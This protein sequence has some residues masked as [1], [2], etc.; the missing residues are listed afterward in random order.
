MK[1]LDKWAERIYAETDVGRSIATSVA[2]VMGLSVY[3]LSSDW[4]IALFSAVIAFP[5]VRLVATGFHARAVRRAQVQME[6][7]EADRKRPVN[8]S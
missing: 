1:A 2:G 6:L 7:E 8:P 5:L 4:V 3:L